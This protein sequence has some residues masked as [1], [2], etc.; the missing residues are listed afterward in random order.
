MSYNRSTA[1]VAAQIKDAIA[2]SG[3][4]PIIAGVGAWQIPAASA[5]AKG[6]VYRQIGAA[7]INFFSYDGMTREGRTERYLEKVGLTLFPSRGGKP[8]WRRGEAAR[9]F[10]EQYEKSEKTGENKGGPG[11]G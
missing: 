1:M 11:A 6:K 9:K 8:N 10:K 3:G 7:G 2:H 4:K 5:I